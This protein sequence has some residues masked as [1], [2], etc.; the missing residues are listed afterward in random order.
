MLGQ[1]KKWSNILMKKLDKVEVDANKC[2]KVRAVTSSCTACLD[3]CPAGAISIGRDLV[4]VNESCIGCG[5]CTNVCQTNALKWNHPPLMQIFQRV[6]RL[7]EKDEDVYIACASSLKGTV[8]D[9][10]GRSAL[11]WN[12][13]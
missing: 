6:C 3:I 10:C 5:L 1:M 7:A 9:Q 4:E 2:Q 8:K 11:S 13:S 12:A